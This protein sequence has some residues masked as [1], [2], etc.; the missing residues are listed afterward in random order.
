MDYVTFGRTGLPV[1]V[2]GLGCG[3]SSRIGQSTRK[4]EADSIPSQNNPALFQNQG[5]SLGSADESAQIVRRTSFQ[6]D[7]SCFDSELSSSV[8]APAVSALKLLLNLK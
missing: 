2:M 3:G 5:W 7:G 8:H 4:S 6:I 1:S